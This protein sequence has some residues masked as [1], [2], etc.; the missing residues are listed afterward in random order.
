MTSLQAVFLGALQGLTEFLPVSSSGHLIL[1]ENFFGLDFQN[2]LIFD[3]AVHAG[4]LGALAVYFWREIRQI[5]GELLSPARWS[6]RLWPLFF[7]TLP[8]VF[9]G[10]FG[11]KW[12]E[13]G[14]RSPRFVAWALL[15]TALLLILTDFLSKKT[16][17]QNTENLGWKTALGIG[18][19]QALAVLPGVSRSGSTIAGGVF[20]KLDKIAAAQFSFLLGMVAILGALV[21]SLPDFASTSAVPS[22]TLA[23]GFGSAFLSG[24]GTVWLF[25]KILPRLPLA[26]FSIYLIALGAGILL[27]LNQFLP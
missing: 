27:E 10:I 15:F 3:I 11:K 16:L 13:H 8:A 24:L 21:L 14:V 19:F 2:L 17:R 9:V 4:T 26:I 6:R 23:I 7:G 5:L 22:A 25:L 1:L 20:L 18:F 12:L